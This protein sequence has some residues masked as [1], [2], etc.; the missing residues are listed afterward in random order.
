MD[1]ICM[2]AASGTDFSRVHF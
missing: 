1:N 2:N